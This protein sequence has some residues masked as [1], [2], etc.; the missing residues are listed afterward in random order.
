MTV[1]ELLEQHVPYVETSECDICGTHQYW[2]CSCGDQLLDE[3][4]PG[5]SSL[6]NCSGD[7]MDHLKEAFVNTL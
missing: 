5:H 1:N 7:F 2:S 3:S 6:G 4:I